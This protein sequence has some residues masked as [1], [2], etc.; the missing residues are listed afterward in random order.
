MAT[1][2]RFRENVCY[3]FKMSVHYTS[4]NPVWESE[5]I[6]F[7]C[8]IIEKGKKAYNPMS[9]TY[10]T[11]ATETWLSDTQ[12]DFAD[13]DRVSKL[14]YPIDEDNDYSIISDLQQTDINPEG[15]RYRNKVKQSIRFV[16]D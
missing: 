6:P 10:V 13:G 5:G 4:A 16:C 8:N 7:R 15:N 14:K 3:L 2:E 1:R 12:I 9:G 11:T